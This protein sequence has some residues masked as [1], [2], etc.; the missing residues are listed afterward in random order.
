MLLTLSVCTNA[1]LYETGTPIMALMVS[2]SFSG[3][4]LRMP[5]STFL[6]YSSVSSTRV[7]VGARKCSFI[8]PAS[9]LGKKSVPT[10]VASLRLAIVMPA[11]TSSVNRRWCSAAASAEPYAF[12]KR[13]KWRSRQRLK[14]TATPANPRGDADPVVV[15]LA[16]HQHARQRR[17]QRARQDVRRE[18][19]QHD[20]DRERREQEARRPDQQ[21][22]RKEHDADRQRRH[23]RRHGDLLRAVEDRARERLAHVAVAVDVLDL[24]RGVVDQHADRQRQPAQGHDVDGVAGELEPDDRRE[25]RQRD[26]RADDHHAAPAAQE[27]ADHQRHQQRRD[28]RLAHDAADGAAHEQRLVEVDLQLEA[29]G[30]RRLDHRQHVAHGIDHRQ[31]RRVGVL[32]DRQVRRA[33][34]VDAHDVGL[35]GERVGDVRDVGQRHRRAVDDLDRDAARTPRRWAGCC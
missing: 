13:S 23:D 28:D 19:R 17:H 3:I 2:I 16:V 20:R 5:V 14:R 9:T 11:A 4:T 24:D 6:M 30:R 33:P 27:Q 18:H 31:R 26:R 10:T 8:K 35:V 32:E 12:W 7:P 15:V 22:D 29:V 21:H 25:D 1:R 34:A